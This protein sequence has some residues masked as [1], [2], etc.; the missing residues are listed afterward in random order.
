MD[1]DTPV[2]G[3]VRDGGVVSEGADELSRKGGGVDI[4]GIEDAVG[5]VGTVATDRP[6]DGAGPL[7][8]IRLAVP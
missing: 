2:G 8:A 6:E 5:T 4:V 7:A 1:G 3:G